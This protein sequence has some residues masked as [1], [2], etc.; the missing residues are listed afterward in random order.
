MN[1][2]PLSFRFNV[3]NHEIAIS[4]VRLAHFILEAQN[5][6]ATI[7]KDIPVNSLLSMKIRTKTVGSFK[8][9][10]NSRV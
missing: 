7:K 9:D 1:L 6:F 5:G 8:I 10:R 4:F 3:D 2:F